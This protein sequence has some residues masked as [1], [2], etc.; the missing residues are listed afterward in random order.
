MGITSYLPVRG[1]GRR[2]K[3]ISPAPWPVC[4]LRAV[5]KACKMSATILISMTACDHRLKRDLA[6]VHQCGWSF[7][8]WIV[9][10]LT[11]YKSA[12]LKLIVAVVA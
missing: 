9:I 8:A 3:G 10:L 12:T 7:R 4:A 11:S 2:S 5:D 6:G 1:W